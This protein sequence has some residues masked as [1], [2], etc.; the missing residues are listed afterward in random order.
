[1]R[2]GVHIADVIDVVCEH[3]QCSHIDLRSHRR[4]VKV[5][6]PR[7]I[8]MYLAAKITERSLPQIGEALGGRDHT[9]VLHGARKITAALETDAK[10]AEDV[11]SL[12][13]AAFAL[14]QLRGRGVL[15]E[16]PEPVSPVEIARRVLAKGRN[17]ALRL[18]PDAVLELADALLAQEE[19][20]AAREAALADLAARGIAP[21]PVMV[22]A[23]PELLFGLV[24]DFV[25]VEAMLRSKPSINLRAARDGL[26]EKLRWRHGES[27]AVDALVAAHDAMT[28]AEYTAAERD[29]TERYRAAVTAL[30]DEFLKSKETANV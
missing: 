27:D 26:I 8:A 11:L 29:A 20:A 14:A 3:F 21:E 23:P 9:T 7:Q 18:P 19:D 6:M 5:V 13:S 17:G 4:T 25:G 22:P 2:A 24:H 28:R 12:E 30:A 15:P 1:M 16:P 10:L